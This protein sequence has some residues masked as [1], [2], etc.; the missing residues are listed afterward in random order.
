MP[1][2]SSAKR[3]A[4]KLQTSSYSYALNISLGLFFHG[5]FL[6]LFDAIYFFSTD[7]KL[8]KELDFP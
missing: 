5:N 3:C 4:E 1:I 6:F 2:D 7:G 8:K